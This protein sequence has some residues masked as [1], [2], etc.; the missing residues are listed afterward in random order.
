MNGRLMSVN[1]P[2][3]HRWMHLLLSAAMSLNTRRFCSRGAA[4]LLMVV[5]TGTTLS[6]VAVRADEPSIEV[7]VS[8]QEIF[9]GESLDFQVDI[10]NAETP[11]AP[12]L[13]VLKEQFDVVSRGDQSRNQ[14]STFIV[15]GR[16]TQQNVFSHI[17][18][19][20]LTPRASG[21]LTIPPLSVTVDGKEVVSEPVVI[22]VQAAEEQDLVLVEIKPDRNTVY[23][24]QPF[25]VTARV[26]V[27]PLPEDSGDPLRP[28]RRQPP[29]LQINWVDSPD[30]LTTNETSEWL[31]PL[32]SDDGSGF[33]LNEITSSSGSFFG[34]SRAALFDLAKGRETRN[35]LNG[36]PVQYYVY[37]LSRSFTPEEN[38]V[39]TFGPVVVKGTFA[40][41]VEGGE[42][43]GRRIVTTASAVTVEVKDVPSPRPAQFTG[44]IGE[45]MIAAS[46]S[47]LKLRVG[48]PLTLT[49]EFARGTQSGSLERVAAPDLSGVPQVAESFEIIDK[50]PTGRTDGKVKRFSYAMRP[51]KPGVTIPS[52]TLSTF[53]PT[54]EAFVDI[55][56]DPIGLEVSEASTVSAVDLV[57]TMPAAATT[58][59]RRSTAGIFQNVMDPAQV[60]DE[61]INVRSWLLTAGGCWCVAGG[62]IAVVTG[63]RRRSG[64][65]AG[66]RRQRARQN[67]ALKLQEAKQMQSTGQTRDALKQIRAA[68]AGLVADM[69]N[70]LADG[71]TTADI[72]RILQEA[73]VPEADSMATQQLLTAME[74]AEYGGGTAA[75]Q[76]ATPDQAGALIARISPILERSHS[77]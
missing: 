5:L 45:Y 29:H 31:Q 47:P 15:N 55:T 69:N 67:A 58:E 44:A 70:L 27:A 21:T 41:G 14:S 75:G 52:L 37:E 24:T 74:D 12:D 4:V 13:S 46:A 11:V 34:G 65:S 16:V 38:G 19:Y 68:I 28:L 32:V 49:L 72:I 9:L 39:Y 56:T 18:L 10:R 2:H 48:D 63:Q 42:L 64:D 20:Q 43:V 54:K 53:D 73:G 1:S 33:T 25:T 71:L 6:S 35:D 36:N 30:G 3:V 61:R 60:F 17:Y 40:G 59:I 22:R 66:L 76:A 62:V 50:S 77:R 23:P 51:K 26:L 7:A 57:G 8:T